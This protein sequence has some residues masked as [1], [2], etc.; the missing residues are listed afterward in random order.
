MLF[1]SFFEN[2]NNLLFGLSS[3]AFL[4]FCTWF[5]S[6]VK[7]AKGLNE[8]LGAFLVFFLIALFRDRYMFFVL[9]GVSDTVL[10]FLRLFLTIVATVLLLEAANEILLSKD[11]PMYILFMF[12]SC[13]LL[14]SL[15]AVFMTNSVVIE[16]NIS[17]IAP[18]IGF[19]Y[20][21]LSFVSKPNLKKNKGLFAASLCML[22]FIEQI[23]LNL[24]FDVHFSFVF[25]IVLLLILAAALCMM[26]ADT[27]DQDK[28]RIQENLK[29][30]SDNIENI[31]KSSPFP[32]L[33]SRLK[34]DAIVFA[35]QNALKVFDMNASELAMYHFGDF[36]VDSDNK[37]L[38]LERL[39]HNR[40]VQDF[41]VLIKT[42]ASSTPFW[43]MVSANVIEY[44][45]EP[46]LYTAFQDIT[47]RK[48][49]EQKLQSQANRDPLTS[50]YNR[51]YFEQIVPTKI[52]KSHAEKQPFAIL[53]VDADHFKNINDRYG[54]KTGDKVLMEMAQVIERSLR[55]DDI[56]ARFGG[57]EF[58]AFL[59]NVAED[60]AIMVANRLREGIANLVVYSDDGQPVT[61]TVSIGVA[62]SGISDHI[63]LMIKMADDAMYMAKNCGRNR[64]EKYDKSKMAKHQNH[65]EVKQ[66]VH[67]ALENKDEY[68]ISLLDGVDAE[69]LKEE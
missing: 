18:L 53:M 20:L 23:A 6:S 8:M 66:Q 34:N 69:L 60:T 19:I 17:L 22:G 47:S 35:N 40:Q 64:V 67:P 27:R 2:V 3:L 7:Y 4:G 24:L 48:E 57:E 43:M 58:V 51:R 41:E 42:M 26:T 15:Y 44:K 31:I 10:I 36:L 56:V 39:E 33:I 68:E 37:K 38:L 21:F 32:I 45:D 11:L 9:N 46:M 16:E 55:P 25:T 62:P 61:W 29:K 14:I 65:T 5:A 59:N 30:I 52:Q 49:K 1:L 13:G 54:H 12:I 50:I 63:D 28:N